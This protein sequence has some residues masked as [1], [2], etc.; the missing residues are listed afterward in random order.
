MTKRAARDIIVAYEKKVRN[1]AGTVLSLMLVL[2]HLDIHQM[3]VVIDPG[4]TN[5]NVGLQKVTLRWYV[6]E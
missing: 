4:G 1:I 6:I 3:D 5:A 2:S